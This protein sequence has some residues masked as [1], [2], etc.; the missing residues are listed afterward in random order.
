MPFFAIHALFFGRL[1]NPIFLSILNLVGVRTV[2]HRLLFVEMLL[3]FSYPLDNLWQFEVG[4][5]LKLIQSWCQELHKKLFEHL[6]LSWKCLD[7][8]L[9]LYWLRIAL[10]IFLFR[11]C[12]YLH[13]F[14]RI[15]NNLPTFLACFW[16]LIVK[17]MFIIFFEWQLFRLSLFPWFRCFIF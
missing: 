8:S 3:Q 4:N 9:F 5:L 14:I 10:E 15:C 1:K 13:R 16:P 2:W 6:V 7:P 17:M 11:G 12:W